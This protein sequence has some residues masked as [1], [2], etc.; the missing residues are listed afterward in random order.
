M[1]TP[2]P[3]P[4][5]NALAGLPLGEV[6]YFQSI[7]STNTCCVDW[8]GKNAADLSLVVADHQSAGRGRENRRW[9]TNPGAALAFS[10]LLRPTD[11]EIGHLAYFSP[12]GA[13]AIRAALEKSYGL[14]GEVKWPND[15]LVGRR[16]LAGILVENLW[17]GTTLQ[18]I[19]IGIGINITREALPPPAELLFPATCVE[20]ETGRPADRWQLMAAVLKELRTWRAVLVSKEFYTEWSSHMAFQGERVSIS[21]SLQPELVGRLTGVD[22]GGNLLITSD[23]GV[24]HAIMVGDVRLRAV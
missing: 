6:R 15:V 1:L 12:L 17:D 21:G 8:A 13:V 9:V 3:D 24:S 23:D 20:M 22:T 5:N 11:K 2:I 4:L 16:K 10:I 14:K 18:A 19:I 7:D